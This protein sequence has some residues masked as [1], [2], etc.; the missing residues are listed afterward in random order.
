[1]KSSIREWLFSV[2]TNFSNLSSNLKDYFDSYGGFVE[3]VKSPYLVLSFILNLFL[4]KSWTTSL[5][6]S[7]VKEIIPS[8]LGFSLGAYAII[9]TFGNETFQKIIADEE[10]GN[11]TLYRKI[12]T[13]FIHFIM[14]QTLSLLFAILCPS[15]LAL[16]Y[17]FLEIIVSFVGNMIFIYSIFLAIASVLTIFRVTKIYQRYINVMQKNKICSKDTSHLS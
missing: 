16:P 9:A 3:M 13:A 2:K 17:G 7:D 1:M 12:N 10:E 5:W 8:I 4:Y 11:N 14:V 6:I 15:L